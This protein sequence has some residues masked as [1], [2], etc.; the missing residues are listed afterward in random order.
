MFM[1]R[2]L[3]I[4]AWIVGVIVV[5]IIALG[6][7]INATWDKSSDRPV[8]QLTASKDSATIA[9]GE[10]LFKYG[11]TC[12]QC[13]ATKPHPDAPPSG[14]RLFDL[15]NVGPGFGMFYTLNITP[16]EETGIG[17]WTDGQVVRAI[18]EG[19]RYDG[20]PLFPL[21][22]VPTL[23]GLSDEDVLAIVSYL[24]SIPP[25]KNAVTPH[26]IRFP[27]K[28]LFALGVVGPE[29]AITE[30]IIAPPKGLT[31]E[32]G[33]YLANHASLCSD[34]H[35]PRDLNTGAFHFDSLMAGS[36]IEFGRVEG[37]PIWAFSANITPDPETG[38]GNWTEQ[39]F[40][41]AV[42]AGMRPDGRVL[43]G[44]MPYSM[45][46]LWEED[47]LRAIYL[48]LKTIPQFRRTTAPPHWTEKITGTSGKE[49]GEA[50]FHSYCMQCHGENGTGAPS[51]KLKMAELAHTID[52]ATLKQ[53][54]HD[55]QVN[56]RMP[57]FGKTFSSEQ[58]EDVI[59]FI[60]SWEKK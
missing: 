24:R 9:R 39:D 36:T 32:Y 8:V 35:T 11:N 34:C 58:I 56:L 50:L 33:K 4:L 59:A 5:L 22:P 3:K 23:K 14:G 16:D 30:P 12:W 15:T 48:Y 53:F 18:R 7:Y 43:A 13:H 45:Y 47:D 51:T 27:T 2:I 46:G 21:M 54:I 42:R 49:R 52:D 37:D 29:P 26:D 55:G 1:K 44:H 10:F 41:L 40:L 38:I 60:R 19:I 20:K 17:R 28:A 6:L 57:A 31:V 25:V